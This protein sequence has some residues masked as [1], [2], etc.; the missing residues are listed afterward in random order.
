MIMRSFFCAA[1][2]ALAG[3]FASIAGAGTAAA[4]SGPEAR[5]FGSVDGD[6]FLFKK[7]FKSLRKNGVGSYCLLLSEKLMPFRELITPS[8]TVEYGGSSGDNLSAYYAATG[9]NDGEVAVRTFKFATGGNNLPSDDVAFVI[10]I[11]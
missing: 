8:V 1:A 6:R 2:L 7:G 11:P 9:C 10:F 3:G 4:Q 5:A